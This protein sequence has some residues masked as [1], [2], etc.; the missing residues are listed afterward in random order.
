MANI[1]K[2]ELIQQLNLWGAEKISAEQLQD[3]MI[4]HYDPPEVEIGIGETEWVVEAMN[5][6][7]NEY[8]LAK[9]EKFKP[10]GY[11]YALAFLE[12]DQDTFYQR[13]HAFVHDGFSD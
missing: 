10:E 9:L 7:M 11:Q 1:T 2:T 3:W 5:I 8:E 4:T 6:I 12:S 13:K